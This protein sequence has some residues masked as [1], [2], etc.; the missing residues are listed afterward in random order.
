MVFVQVDKYLLFI[1][2]CAYCRSKQ[3]SVLK[4][5]K[6]VHWF[7]IKSWTD[8]QDTAIAFEQILW[9]CS[10]LSMF[11]DACYWAY[12]LLWAHAH[13]ILILAFLSS[14]VLWLPVSYSNH[15]F[16]DNWYTSQNIEDE[17]FPKKNLQQ[18]IPKKEEIL[19]ASFFWEKYPLHYDESSLCL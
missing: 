15:L 10:F 18:N 6:T 2:S 14:I 16:S 19:A 9:Q 11:F 1:N 7:L 5:K 13:T 3:L 4:V 12:Y 8:T 17:M